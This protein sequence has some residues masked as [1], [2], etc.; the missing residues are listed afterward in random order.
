MKKIC[1]TLSLILFL[2][3]CATKEKYDQ[4]LQTWI[5]RPETALLQKWGTPSASKIMMNGD[6]V[7]TYTKA[8]DV[9]V[10]SE[11]YLN[12]PNM[13]PGQETVYSPFLNEYDFTPYNAAFGYQVEDICQTSFLVQG[14]I[15]TGW[16]WKGNNCVAF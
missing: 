4:K 1:F 13:L 2:F 3:A 15:I 5:G 14:G 16:K 7:I 6:K 10:P 11:F 8:N 12:D 9:Y